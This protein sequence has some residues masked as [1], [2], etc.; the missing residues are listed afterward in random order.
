V[1]RIGSESI[2]IPK[3]GRIVSLTVLYSALSKAEISPGDYFEI[4]QD[5]P[6]E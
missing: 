2:E 1:Q 3:R 6:N 5:L 4:L